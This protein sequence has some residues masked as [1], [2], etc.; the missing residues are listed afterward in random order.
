VAECSLRRPAAIGR[1]SQSPTVSGNRV[2][3]GQHNEETHMKTTMSKARSS[4]GIG[5][6]HLPP[7]SQ[8]QQRGTSF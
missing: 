3:V 5:Q 4:E 8:N 2:V 7:E 1:R 6:H